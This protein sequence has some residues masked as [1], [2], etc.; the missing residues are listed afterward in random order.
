MATKTTFKNYLQ[1]LVE[2]LQNLPDTTSFTPFRNFQN[3]DD[4]AQQLNL[5]AVQMSGNI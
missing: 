5:E 2:K 1:S 4:F 3:D